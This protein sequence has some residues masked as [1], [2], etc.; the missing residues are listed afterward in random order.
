MES[1]GEIEHCFLMWDLLEQL[2]G[3]IIGITGSGEGLLDRTEIADKTD[4]Y[5][6][7]LL[8]AHLKEDTT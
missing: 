6:F 1:W 4:F 3:T 7:P 2:A 5:W 8:L